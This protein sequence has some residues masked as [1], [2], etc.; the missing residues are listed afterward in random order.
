MRFPAREQALC[1]LKKSRG[2]TG[3]QPRFGVP[4]K[5]LISG[6][7]STPFFTPKIL[8]FLRDF[9]I[10]C[11][12]FF[13]HFAILYGQKIKKNEKGLTHDGDGKEAR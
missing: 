2:G 12:L 13:A 3:F 1:R 7:F 5:P 11:C 4:Y 9:A 6:A 10:F 8:I